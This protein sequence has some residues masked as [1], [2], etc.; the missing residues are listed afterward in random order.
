MV[1]LE[2]PFTVTLLQVCN[3]CDSGAVA[4]HSKGCLKCGRYFSVSVKKFH[5][6][7]TLLLETVKDCRLTYVN[8]VEY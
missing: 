3:F 7:T 5:I 4:N 2:L 6:I 8:E 1:R